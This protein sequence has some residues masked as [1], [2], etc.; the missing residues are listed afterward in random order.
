MKKLVEL[1]V[2]LSPLLLILILVFI[3]FKSSPWKTQP[4]KNPVTIKM[5]PTVLPESRFEYLIYELADYSKLSLI[6]NNKQQESIKLV[7]TNDCKVAINGGFYDLKNRP[8][9]LMIID[10]QELYPTIESEL[11]N[12]FLWLSQLGEFGITDILPNIDL[13]LSLQSGPLLFQNGSP[14][15]LSILNDKLARRSVM[16]TLDDGNLLLVTIFD[17][18][19]AFLGPYLKQLPTVLQEIADE[20]DLVII[21]AI[22]LDGGSAS[23]FKNNKRYLSEYKSIGSMFCITE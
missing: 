20:N 23:M 11:L 1:I 17:G 7:E 16:A 10:Q 3:S 15:P 14:L 21:D 6:D 4:I 12:G 5:K 8:L 18:Q 13:E 22:N 9:G 19:S 2:F